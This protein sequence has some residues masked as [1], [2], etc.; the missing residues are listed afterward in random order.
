MNSMTL[1]WLLVVGIIGSC[2]LIFGL[3]QV[4]KARK[5]LDRMDSL[6]DKAIAGEPVLVQFDEAY[7]SKIEEN[8][9]R[10]LAI[11]QQQAQ[12][13]Q[14]EK[15]AVKQLIANISH[16]T[17]TPLAN[18]LLYNQLIMEKTQEPHTQGFSQEIERQSEKMQFFIERLTKAAYLEDDLIQLTK[19]DQP[20]IDLL[21]QAIDSA[22]AKAEEKQIVI[23]LQKTPLYAS[24]DFRWTLEA[25]VNVLDNAIKYSLPDTAITISCE[26]YEFFLKILISDEGQGISE[27]EQAQVFERFYRGKAAQQSEGLGIGLF[28]VREIVSGQG[29]FVKL[30]A[31]KKHGTDVSLYLPK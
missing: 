9:Q 11:Q 14:A 13:S 10:F 25:V 8:L 20:L 12:K 15:L 17:K 26:S 23:H 27:E 21:T 4:Y 7:P 6:L 1:I 31:N 30:A 2:M 3:F 24:Y 22:R 18:I 28:L 19:N 16:Q 5:V 29:G